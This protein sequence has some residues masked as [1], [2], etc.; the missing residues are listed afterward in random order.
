M[1]SPVNMKSFNPNKHLKEEFV[2]NLSGTSMLE[3]FLLITTLSMILFLRSVYSST[4][5]GPNSAEALLKKD[6]NITSSKKKDDNINVVDCNKNMGSYL[7]AV[8]LDVIWIVFPAILCLTILADWTYINAVVMTLLVAFFIVA[9]RSGFSVSQ[10][11]GVRSL[12]TNISAYRVSM[13]LL[14]CVCILAVDFK[15]FPRR[16]AK[17]ETYGTGLMDIGVG[18]FI[19]A[20][21]LVSRQA[22]GIAKM[23]LRN[24]ISSTCPLIVLGFARIFFTSTVD[25]QVHV[26]EY[27]VHWNFFFTLAAVAIL[28]SMIN[29]SP[30]NCGI[31]GWFI[32]LGYEVFLLLGLN[33]YLLSS[34]R[35]PDIISQ[36]KEGIFSIFG[37]WGLYL[38]CVQ[39]GSYLFFGRPG[40][41]VLRTNDWARIRVWIL[42]LLLW[43]LT[44][45]LDMCVERVSRRM[46]NLAYVTV[47]LAMNLQVF[48]VL[49]LAD[50][51][52]GYKVAALI[53]VFD[54]N[55]LG[56]FL[57]ANVLTGLVN[58]SI[59]TLFV[60][61][62]TA[63]AIL[64][65][66]A[67][68]LS[69]AAAVA[70]VCGIRL[71]FW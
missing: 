71:K 23:N 19:V 24:A 33:E 34:E 13:N 48:A 31:L 21:A 38:V 68:I 10:E 11:E 58:L 18:S 3:L 6:D 16:Y 32:L 69:I 61:P 45:F 15:I 22:R 9:R 62:F 46:C 36:N 42:C 25:Y 39:I 14:T 64:V 66:Y 53:E 60:S 17:T 55:L 26:G 7:A 4:K 67:Y 29:L 1:D 54:R 43:L 70:H 47:V 27:G 49:T 51:V 59:D 56:S 41:A 40:D 20:N 8:T 12:R 5:K 37:Y 50:Y 44:V 63:L 28:T 57:L 52:P 2:S 35:G 65:G 30:S